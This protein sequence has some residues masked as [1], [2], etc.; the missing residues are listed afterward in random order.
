MSGRAGPSVLR[1]E[2]ST[3]KMS[4]HTKKQK[5]YQTLHAYPLALG[6]R[7]SR[8]LCEVIPSVLISGCDPRKLPGGL[9]SFPFPYSPELR[10]PGEVSGHA[11]PPSPWRA[12]RNLPDSEFCTLTPTTITSVTLERGSSPGSSEPLFVQGVPQSNIPYGGVLVSPFSF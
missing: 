3:T 2:C 8:W 4:Y 1:K 7:R 12:Q 10:L 5:M 6:T 11:P 9:D